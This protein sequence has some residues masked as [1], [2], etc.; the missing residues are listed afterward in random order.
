MQRSAKGPLLERFVL[1]HRESGRRGHRPFQAD[2]L[3]IHHRLIVVALG[4]ARAPHLL[5]RLNPRSGGKFSPN[6]IYRKKCDGPLD[7][8]FLFV[9]ATRVMEKGWS[10]ASRV[11]M[12]HSRL[13]SLEQRDAVP[14]PETPNQPPLHRQV[15]LVAVTDRQFEKM[16]P[17]R[18]L[19]A[20]PFHADFLNATNSVLV[21]A[22]RCAFNNK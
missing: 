16:A 3:K 20:R 18:N 14:A 10:A 22:I 21:T 5:D 2:P 7:V 6:L 15:R 9:Y 4:R 12:A 19:A 1:N 11:P 8:R 13:T 17:R